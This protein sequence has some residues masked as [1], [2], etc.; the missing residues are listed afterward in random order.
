MNKLTDTKTLFKF[1]DYVDLSEKLKLCYDNKFPIEIL[2]ADCIK[3]LIPSIG[4]NYINA[5]KSVYLIGRLVAIYLNR[6][7]KNKT[8]G[9]VR[10]TDMIVIC[11]AVMVDYESTY[12]A[13]SMIPRS[14]PKTEEGMSEEMKLYYISH[15]LAGPQY[16][17][18][19][20]LEYTLPCLV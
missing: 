17:L 1:K 18:L 7:A 5:I 9:R 13:T 12:F 15:T 3:A 20:Q 16:F 2:I 11:R 14:M 19:K 4:L 10:L 6:Y 8:E